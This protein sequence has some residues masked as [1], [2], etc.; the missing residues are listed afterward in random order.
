MS[1]RQR[2]K[3]GGRPRLPTLAEIEA[4]N[5]AT[6]EEGPGREDYRKEAKALEPRPGP[7]V[8]QSIPE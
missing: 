8:I 6:E 7:S 1:M 5:S 4:T 2:G 3:L